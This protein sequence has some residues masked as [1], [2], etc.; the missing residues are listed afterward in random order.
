MNR[1]ATVAAAL[2][3][4][5]CGAQ[6]AAPELLPAEN[7]AASIDGKQ[8]NLYTLHAGD[9]T[10]QATNYGARVVSLWTPD[11][12]G[13]CEDIVLG[14]ETLD[15][16]VNNTGERFLGAVVGPYANRIAAG[17]FTLD[18]TEYTLPTNDNG[19]TLHGGMTGLDRV[20]WDVIE[21]TEQKLVLSYLHRDGE[22]G[23][24]GNLQIT[25][26]YTVTPE[27]EF[28]VDYRAT[29]DKPTVV[30]LSHHSFFNLKGEGNGTV[31]DNVLT[32]HA[33]RTTP[34]DSVLIPTGEIADVTGTPFDFRQP[35]AIGERIEADNAQLR[36]GHGYDHNYVLNTQGDIS[37]VAA[38]VY[39][40]KSGRTLEVYT[41]EPGI[42]V[43]TGNFLDGTVSGK[44]G[45][46][47][48]QRAS[49]CLETQHYPDSPNKADW[50][51]VVLEPGQTY[52][53]ECIFKFSVEK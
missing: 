19:Q 21:A 9:I 20:V 31:L 10:L 37:Q 16:Y 27:N 18:G 34:V 1:I 25:M 44:K 3:L 45:I 14:Y 4:A 51:S 35:H 49:V 28:R 30:N 13:R 6:S 12:E 43:Y 5:G 8:V 36:N 24:P 26:T 29:T 40:P 53:S 47:Y 23:F 46:V 32:I 22:E 50:P 41:N 15:R 7:F 39:D 33:S 42:Q 11:R 17:H 52:N 2:L 38:K 48:N